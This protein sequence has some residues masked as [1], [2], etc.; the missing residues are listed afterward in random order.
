MNVR[1]GW[2]H[3]TGRALIL[4][5]DNIDTDQIYPGRFLSLTDRSEMKEAF[6]ADC[7]FAST[8]DKVSHKYFLPQQSVMVAGENFGCGSSRE[9]AVW[10]MVDHGFRAVLALSFAP[11][12]RQNAVANGIAPIA[13]SRELYIELS[14]MQNENVEF[15]IDILKK[16]FRV[17]C[18]DLGFS[19]ISSFDLD[20]FDAYCLHNGLDSLGFL[21]SQ[22][23]KTK[24]YLERKKNSLHA[25]DV[26]NSGG[27]L[28]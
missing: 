21:I 10:V 9:H 7:R 17:H 26:Y 27:T 24:E 4:S 14:S 6:F 19:K 5:R 23:N 11:I 25:L 1:R 3:C 13:I 20:E 2:S 12:F 28:S 8:G 15:D 22:K 18:S 16:Q